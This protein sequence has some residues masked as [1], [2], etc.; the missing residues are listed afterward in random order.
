MWGYYYVT[1]NTMCPAVLLEMGFA[2][3]PAEYESLSDDAQI[4]AAG[5]AIARGRRRVPRGVKGSAADF[6]GGRAGN[7]RA[8]RI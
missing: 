1:R 5:E 2:A 6:C 3:S 7:P 8:L 4:W